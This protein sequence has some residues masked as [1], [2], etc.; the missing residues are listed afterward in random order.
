ML[1]LV[2]YGGEYQSTRLLDDPHKL[3]ATAPEEWSEGRAFDEAC[4]VIAEHYKIYY[5]SRYKKWLAE[6]SASSYPHTL[7]VMHASDVEETNRGR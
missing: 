7:F 2:F 6:R 4:K 1:A 5:P 3:A